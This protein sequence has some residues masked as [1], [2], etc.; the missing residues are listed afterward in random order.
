M[1]LTSGPALFFLGL[2][3]AFGAVGGIETSMT[4][5]ELALSTAFAF[6]GLGLAYIGVQALKAV[7]AQND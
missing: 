7:D 1:K 2:L 3:I 6:F 4:N 5:T